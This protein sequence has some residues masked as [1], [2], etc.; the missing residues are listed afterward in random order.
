MGLKKIV[1]AYIKLKKVAY[2]LA[3]ELRP[4]RRREEPQQRQDQEGKSLSKPFF[5]ATQED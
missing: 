1:K 5:L 4:R 2:E 3:H